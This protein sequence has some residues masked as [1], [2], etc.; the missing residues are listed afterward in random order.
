MFLILELI[1]KILVRTVMHARVMLMGSSRTCSQLMIVT[2][3][4]NCKL[5]SLTSL[6]ITVR[7]QNVGEVLKGQNYDLVLDC[8]GGKDYFE[9]AKQILKPGM[10]GVHGSGVHYWL[11]VVCFS[12][13]RQGCGAVWGFTLS[14]PHYYAAHT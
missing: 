14:A 1:M 11:Y 2:P 13:S 10:Y 12:A 6:F 5:H 3:L 7:A 8:I 9:A 4:T